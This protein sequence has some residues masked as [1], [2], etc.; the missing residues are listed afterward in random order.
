MVVVLEVSYAGLW[1]VLADTRLLVV[2]PGSKDES[3]FTSRRVSLGVA[4][5]LARE[6]ELHLAHLR[7]ASFALPWQASSRRLTFNSFT[8]FRQ[9]LGT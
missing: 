8:G 7:R 4:H 5:D 1:L 6:E 9:R 3:E 2:R